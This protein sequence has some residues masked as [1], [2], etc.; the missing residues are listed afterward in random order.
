MRLTLILLIISMSSFGQRIHINM[1]K[2]GYLK[3]DQKL[4]TD[5][6]N[7][8]MLFER[9]NTDEQSDNE[10]RVYD[11]DLNEVLAQKIEHADH[12]ILHSG[13]MITARAPFY[14]KNEV[15]L[16]KYDLSNGELVKEIKI[17][18]DFNDEGDWQKMAAES[19]KSYYDL[20]SNSDFIS[21]TSIPEDQL[22]QKDWNNYME[23]DCQFEI[24]HWLFN[25]N[26]EQVAQYKFPLKTIE[27]LNWKMISEPIIDAEGNTYFTMMRPPNV[28]VHVKI[29]SK[30]NMT[31]V[32]GAQKVRENKRGK[33]VII[34]TA[35]GSMDEENYTIHYKTFAEPQGE[36]EASKNL[37]FVGNDYNI[38]LEKQTVNFNQNSCKTE[39]VK[40]FSQEFIRENGLKSAD[41]LRLRT[42]VNHPEDPT[43]QIYLLEAERRSTTEKEI[44][45]DP[46]L[47]LMEVDMNSNYM[48]TSEY[49][50]LDY[51]ILDTKNDRHILIE[52]KSSVTEDVSRFYSWIGIW[53][54]RAYII[55][56]NHK[57]GAHVSSINLHTGEQVHQKLIGDMNAG[58]IVTQY[59]NLILDGYLYYMTINPGTRACHLNRV[60]L[61]T[62][63][64]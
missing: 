26:L 20:S 44:G 9:A 50:L 13:H 8:V 6:G 53:Q 46:R 29:D 63:L 54:N 60:E 15:K 38:S 41:M 7:L 33:P 59:Y 34:W 18:K 14:S 56:D 47:D 27:A 23:N 32:E 25:K 3:G 42:R 58:W 43:N 5:N 10:I 2:Y 31:E 37:S 28:L 52:K 12:F 30:G 49:T 21:V 55:Y 45:R 22:S 35:I 40:R 4:H 39:L 16:R 64:Q 17:L 57:N 19:H 11:K 51:Y 61:M 62:K 1:P 36:F 48:T 24:T